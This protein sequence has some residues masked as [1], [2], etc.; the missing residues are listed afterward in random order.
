[1]PNYEVSLKSVKKGSD[2]NLKY[3]TCYINADTEKE[4]ESKVL[5]LE[6]NAGF[7]VWMISRPFPYK[8]KKVYT[9]D[10]GE[11]Y[12]TQEMAIICPNCRYLVEFDSSQEH[13]GVVCPQC[14]TLVV[15]GKPDEREEEGS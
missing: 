7:V 13:L 6:E 12:E 9:S 5:A 1:M 14:G 4:A 2:G 3:K 10:E 11:L 8:M 15:A